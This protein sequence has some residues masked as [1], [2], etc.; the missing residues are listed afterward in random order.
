MLSLRELHMS[1]RARRTR[2]EAGRAPAPRAGARPVQRAVSR[3]WSSATRRRSQP[4]GGRQ[5]SPSAGGQMRGAI[6]AVTRPAVES[7]PRARSADR[8]APTWS[9][10]GT[11]ALVACLAASGVCFLLY[12]V[13]RPFSSEVGA[14]RA[15]AFASSSWVVAHLFVVVG[16]I[17]LALGMLGLYLRLQRT[18]LAGRMV[19][20]LSLSWLGAGLTVSDY[21]AEAFGLHAVGQRTLSIGNTGLLK[22]LT[23]SIRWAAGIYF[24]VAGLLP[25]AAGAVIAALAVWRCERLQRWSAVPLAAGLVLY[26]PQFAAGQSLRVAHGMLM[27]AGCWWL[28]WALTRRSGSLR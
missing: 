8:R 21:G 12:P 3:S 26:I 23:R 20:A 13:I 17:L 11:G 7:V 15:R 28:A 14:A 18:A 27:M 1:L 2:G 22:P 10:P 24:I 5:S 16:F 9:A 19:V 6:D 25:L 4:D